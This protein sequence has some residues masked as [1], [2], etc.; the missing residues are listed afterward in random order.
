MSEAISRVTGPSS[1]VEVGGTSVAV[2]TEVA[3][4]GTEVAPVCE[5]ASVGGTDVL[6]RS[7]AIVGEVADGGGTDVEVGGTVVG[8]AATVV[9]GASAG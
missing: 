6:V 8:T 3:A 2:G 9:V 5:G 7:G 4:V 1:G